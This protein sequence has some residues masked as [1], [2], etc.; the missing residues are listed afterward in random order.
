MQARRAVRAG[1]Q[2]GTIGS[3]VMI[4]GQALARIA[5]GAPMFP[6]LLENAFTSAIPAPVF[7]AVLDS[8]KFQAKP[9]L[10]VGILVL[11][12]VVG[13]LIGAAFGLVWGPELSGIRRRWSGWN[14]GL[15]G[16]VGLWL[17]TAVV[18][19]PVAGDGFFGSQTPFDAVG[20]NFALL[21]NFLLYG[22]TVAGGFR[23]LFTAESAGQ[24][25]TRPERRRLLGGLAV[26]GIAALAAG[27]TYRI[28]TA[29]KPGP[30]TVAVATGPGVSLAI[31]ASAVNSNAAAATVTDAVSPTPGAVNAAATPG[32]VPL[33]SS[34]AATRAAPDNLAAWQIPGLEPD[35]TPTKDF[36]V[37]SKNF[38]SDPVV[39]PKTWKLQI[40]G[41]VSNPY[42]LTFDELLKLASE[43]RF[44]TLECISNE[45]G[46]N[47]IGNAQWR[48]VPLRSLLMKAKVD[49]KA[50]KVVFSA[51]DDY[52]DSIPV[53]RAL[54]PANLL[55]YHMN[56]SFLE[57]GHG[58]PARLLIPGI[59]G[60]KNVKWLTKIEIVKNDF[61]GYWQLR[62]WS[63]SA[64]IQTMS[65]IEV[66]G[67]KTTDLKVGPSPIAGVAFAGDRKISKVEV[68]V[69]G[70]KTWQNAT[71]KPALGPYTWQLW[72]LD[73]NATPGDHDVVVRATDGTGRTQTSTVTETL[74]NGATG[75]HDRSVHV[76][77]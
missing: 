49:A 76:T 6:D 51:A 7:S 33:A 54:S 17:L 67:E 63:D 14:S 23:V 4:F 10:F 73:W 42:S 41:L 22:L 74:P 19:L 68:S 8:L 75:W 29:P 15:L 35:V 2:A 46:G 66:P 18:M 16:G 48:G 1:A 31:P 70:G 50:V 65:R 58:A 3:L 25:T 44:E 69:D 52:A 55:A 53:E 12:I 71:L 32:A 62:G 72:R 45:I 47:L 11:Q 60:M 9:L 39:D 24:P 21:V 5:A 34:N 38:F 43:D 40:T 30:L 26:G 59:Y 20:L 64:V 27:A 36:Y 57:P 56:G 61:Q 28:I 13:A 37:V 77:N